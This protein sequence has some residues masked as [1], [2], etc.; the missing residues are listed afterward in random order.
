VTPPH[1]AIIYRRR[2]RL[3]HPAKRKRAGLADFPIN[4]VAD[5]TPHPLGCPQLTVEISTTPSTVQIVRRLRFRTFF[6]SLFERYADFLRGRAVFP[7]THPIPTLPQKQL[8]FSVRV[9]RRLN[10][11]ARRR[12]VWCWNLFDAPSNAM[13][14]VYGSKGVAIRSTVGHVRRLW[15]TLVVSG[16]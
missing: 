10:E 3:T 5:L 7:A 1:N 8:D 13:W 4:R 11:L 9:S 14:H 2:K 12:A 15:Q 6:G 16:A